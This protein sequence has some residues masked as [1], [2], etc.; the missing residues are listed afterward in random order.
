M[1][2]HFDGER[3]KPLPAANITWVGGLDFDASGRLWIAAANNAGWFEKNGDGEW[4]FHSLWAKIP[5]PAASWRM[6]VRVFAEKNCITFVTENTIFRW[7]GSAFHSWPMLGTRRLL[8][9][10]V[11]DT[12][13]VQYITHGLYALRENGPEL[14]IPA[15]VLGNRA[16]MWMERREKDWLLATSAGLF[17]YREGRLDPF[18]PEV[19]DFL[20]HAG[21]TAGSK[22]GDGRYVF[23]TNGEGIVIMAP[24]GTL[25]RILREEDGLASRFVSSLFVDREGS[26]WGT[27][28]AGVWRM[29]TGPQS[30]FDRRAGVEPS[31]TRYFA[32]TAQGMA[33]AG[34]GGLQ[35]LNTD[36]RRLSKI[37]GIPGGIENIGASRLGL[38]ISGY[39][40]VRL[41]DGNGVTQ[42]FAS[43]YNSTSAFPS[44]LDPDRILVVDNRDVIAVGADGK[45]HV[46]ARDLPD[47]PSD[48]AEDESGNLWIGTMT[49]GLVV[50]QLQPERAISASSLAPSFG[51]PPLVGR[52][53]CRA[54]NDGSI[55]VF[56]D[57]GG[58]LKPHGA[59]LFK[60]IENYFPRGIADVSFVAPDNTVWLA[61]SAADNVA[62]CVA[63]VRV[64]ADGAALQLHSIP[65]LSSI[66]QPR[67]IFAEA[68]EEGSTLL[69]IGGTK[70]VLRH[71]VATGPHAPIPRKPLLNVVAQ[72]GHDDGLHAISEPLPYSTR[73]IQ[74]EFSELEFSRRTL[75]RLETRID[76]IDRDWQPAPADGRRELTAVRDGHYTFRVRAVA[77]TGLASE[78]AT[79]DFEV[80]P[81]WWRTTPALFAGLF[82]LVPLGYSGYWLRVRA[83]RRRN[84]ELEAKVRERTEAL[85]QASAAKTEFV[86]NMSHDIRN[87]LNGIV[88]LALAL[89]DTRLDPKQREIVA[90][91]RECT[92]Y[93]STLVDDVLDF[94]S[95]E[96]G[97]VEL[98]PGPFAPE[99]LLRSIVTSLKGDTAVS[100]ATLR[101]EVDPALPTRLLGDA[102][103]IQ[104]ILVNYVSN[105]LKYAGGEIL[106][107]AATPP[108]APDEVEF[109]VADRGPGIA[110][111]EQVALFTKFTR[112]AAARRDDIPGAGLGLASCRL[113]ADIM[114]GSVGVE[115]EPGRGAR[116]FLRLPLAAATT[117][118]EPATAEL[119]HTTVL[120]V[121][122]TDYNALAAT[123]VLR[124]LGLS[125]ERA[126]TG[127]E[128]LELFAAKRFNLV[129]LDRNL[130]DMDGTEVA[131]KMRA[132]ETDGL[133][134]ILLAVT[135]YCTA[136]DRQLCL[137]AGMDAFVGKPL[138]P[139]KLRKVLLAAGR[140]LLAA[141][142][143]NTAPEATSAAKGLDTSMLNYLSDGSEAGLREQTERFLAGLAETDSRLAQRLAANDFPAL[144]RNAHELLASARM[145]GAEA[146]T[147]A[148]Q[149]LEKAARDGDGATCVRLLAV[150]RAEAQSVTAALRHRRSAELTT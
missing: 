113:L 122:D 82:A 25:A 84:R 62:P 40:G 88:G 11:N 30:A 20:L 32:R 43:I 132:L 89:E 104:Q 49:R 60:K 86:A 41:F 131:R 63:R 147:D 4:Q 7:D 67:G 90:T 107:S 146:L 48:I 129:L 135:A 81:P 5:D 123:A 79:F 77:E 114:S 138:T 108:G 56:A 133:Q 21:L 127:A 78:A 126:R 106:V 44:R 92:M 120:L 94:A 130:P 57:N 33:F 76:G 95:I 38:L 31:T 150:V 97:R 139:E 46:L 149:Q 51:L 115:S 121:E 64:N 117:E 9:L 144:A 53:F 80:L 142:T 17:L 52:T 54:T 73:A 102:G 101:V 13:Y 111:A 124:R 39:R 2:V 105:A 58:W 47:T 72:S 137:D 103:R 27:S 8:A 35:L 109:S 36:R 16:I 119:P 19:S 65:G 116:F 87:P 3:W 22:L 93:L 12:V 141:A 61:Y 50:A 112:L 100:G 34:T 70:S 75:L 98:R 128:A 134:A 71:V 118:A 68:G 29:E 14:L 125:C 69:W 15:T 145:V 18:A 23:G 28:A 91:L 85:E 136:E 96:A 37:Q 10:R 99:E 55:L 66:G 24:D 6:P 148:A 45:T 83:L 140:R 74:F 143:L 26:L 1:V 42:F 110:A 59:K